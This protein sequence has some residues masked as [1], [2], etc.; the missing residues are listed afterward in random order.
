[1]KF[2]HI[3]LGFAI[4]AVF[5]GVLSPEAKSIPDKVISIGYQKVWQSDFAEGQR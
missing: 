3:A 1:V 4:S 5:A 2:A